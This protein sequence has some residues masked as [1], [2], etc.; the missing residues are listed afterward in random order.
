MSLLLQ[1]QHHLFAGICIEGRLFLVF[2]LVFYFLFFP[3]SFFEDL[4][5]VVLKRKTPISVRKD[6]LCPLRYRFSGSVGF[7]EGWR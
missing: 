4:G 2:V 1:I 5:C 6:F 3:F 7:R